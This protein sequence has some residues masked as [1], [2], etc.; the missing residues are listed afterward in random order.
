MAARVIPIIIN[1]APGAGGTAVVTQIAS[2][3]RDLDKEADRA[4]SHGLKTVE[5]GMTS[6]FVAG[7]LL[8]DGLREIFSLIKEGIVDTTLFASRT[9]E[10]TIAL[11]QLAKANGISNEQIDAQ[12]KGLIG[13]NIARQEATQILSQ[14]IGAN[15]DLSKATQLARVA[16]DTAVISGKNSSEAFVDLTNAILLGNTEAFRSAGI[17]LSVT[18]A[19]EKGAKA[20]HLNKDALTEQQRTQVLTNAVI[21]YGARVTGTYEAAMGS[22]SKQMRSLTRLHDDAKE[23]VGGLFQGP[24]ALGVKLAAALLKIIA[25]YPGSFAAMTTAVLALTASLVFYNTSLIPSLIAKGAGLVGMFQNL[26]F[27]TINWQVALTDAQVATS[28]LAGW[29]AVAI[30]IGVVVIALTN[31]ASAAEAANKITLEQIES[32]KV[33]WETSKTLAAAAVEVSSAQEGSAD[34]HQKL[35]AVLGQLDPATRA[36]IESLRSEADRLS[37]V[38]SEMEKIAV[39]KQAPLVASLRVEGGGVLQQMDQIESASARIA[40]IEEQI[41]REQDLLSK[42]PSWA[43]TL[44]PAIQQLSVDIVEH[45]QKREELSKALVENQAKLIANA[46]AL[47]LNRDQMLSVF[48]QAGSTGPQ[49][50]KLGDVWDDLTNRTNK[51]TDALKEQ[52]ATLD[53]V[54]KSLN[55]LTKGS[56]AQ[57]LQIESKILGIVQQA[58]N[59]A[60]ARRMAREALQ[61]DQGFREVIERRKAANEAEKAARNVFEPQVK[62]EDAQRSAAEKAARDRE[63]I[64][65]MKAKIDELAADFMENFGKALPFHFGQTGL[66]TKLNY[67]HR[68]AADISLDARTKEGQFVLEWL[69]ENGINA[70]ASLGQ[71]VSK[72][73]GKLI[74]TG[75]HIHAGELSSGI[76]RDLKLREGLLSDKALKEKTV[77]YQSDFYG[78]SPLEIAQLMQSEASKKQIAQPETGGLAQLPIDVQRQWDLYYE[79]AKKREDALRDRRKDYAAE[80]SA[81]FRNMV[82]EIGNLDLDLAHL[83]QQNADD[84]FVE[85]RRLLMAKGEEVDIT[86][87]I[88]KVQDEIATG[89]Y[90]QALRLELA[91]Q[92]AILNVQH[93]REDALVRDIQNQVQLAQQMD[94]D[95]NRLND[96]VVDFLAHQKTLQETFQDARTNTVRTFFDGIDSAIDKMTKHLGVAGSVLGQFLKDLAHLAASQLL[97]RLLGI[98]NQGQSSGAGAGSGGGGNFFSNITN[99]AGNFFNPSRGGGSSAFGFGAGS[100]GVTNGGSASTSAIGN[101]FSN[102]NPFSSFTNPGISVP[103]SVASGPLTSAQIT[104]AAAQENIAHQASSGLGGLLGFGGG[105]GAGALAAMAPLL[106]V[107]LGAS[108]GGGSV[109]GS[110]LG[111]AGGGLAGLAVAG[112]FGLLPAALAGLA[113]PGAIFAA[114]LIIGAIILA[115]NKARQEAEKK[116]E[117]L[118]NNT[119]LEIWKLIGEARSLGTVAATARWEEIRKNYFDQVAQIKDSKTHRIAV[120]QWGIGPDDPDQNHYWPLWKKVAARAAEGD[121]AKLASANFFPTFAAGGLVPYRGGMLTTIAVTPQERIDDARGF[122]WI[123]PGTDRGYDSVLTQAAPKS[124]VRTRAQQRRFPAFAAGSNTPIGTDGSNGRAD[125]PLVVQIPIYFDA[126]GIVAKGAKSSDGR[127]A[128]AGAMHEDAKINGR[129]GYAGTLEVVLTQRT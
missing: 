52:I 99:A 28:L 81:T 26:V 116:R 78:M 24:F 120:A 122:S 40:Q 92:E 82:T 115:K 80:Y 3:F 48:Q 95:F 127:K 16:Q 96:G 64:S 94:V 7:Q 85:Q 97:Q 66:H 1:I 124:A 65:A 18:D 19:L 44:R 100:N 129:D 68:A 106:G 15:L 55:A 9:E 38:R 20:L 57:Q 6:A 58:K 51:T 90:N 50:T 53:G 12:L 71:E 109:L 17:F 86:R 60:E 73:T 77:A 34:R 13:L 118:S 87:Q 61:G 43:A 83:R 123:V 79:D 2:A 59:S 23:A 103:P 14:M 36:Y 98:G 33:A 112:G 39:L 108:L 74:S 114:P 37:L 113:I 75:V 70:R 128:I 10:L 45:Q 4:G 102:I 32:Q 47:G 91:T 49:L 76:G 25:E 54:K 121:A 72:T 88:G 42:D 104:A 101:L 67:D 62:S 35:N 63:I 111:A 31:Q 93:Q 89:P 30:A 5:N 21:E 84:Q 41:R 110:I 125:S 29:A 56:D 69:N 126:A 119:G 46:Q 8:H 105:G 22:A 11:H 107:G 27:W 117:V